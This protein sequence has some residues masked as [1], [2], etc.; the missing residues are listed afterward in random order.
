MS[1]IDVTVELSRCQNCGSTDRTPYE[2]TTQQECQGTRTDPATGREIA[3]TKIVRRRTCCKA[4]G[5]ARI[6][7]TYEK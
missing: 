1:K 6:D 5:Q 2:G 4:C 7:R 3:F